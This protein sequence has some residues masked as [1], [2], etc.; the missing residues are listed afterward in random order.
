[1]HEVGLVS[2][3]LARAV[4]AAEQAGATRIERLTFAIAGGGH[5]T[6]EVVETLCAALGAG[7]LAE[8]A[9]VACEPRAVDYA[10]FACGTLFQAA[11]RTCPTCG[12]PGV[13]DGDA[14]E[15]ELVSIDVTTEG[16]A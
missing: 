8:G 9:R 5:V 10:C 4:A 1:M 13:A 12:S 15:L 11:D 2:D 16:G 6:P 3:A 14:P 7:T